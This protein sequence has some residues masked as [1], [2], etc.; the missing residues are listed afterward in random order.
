MS[1]KAIIENLS[2]GGWLSIVVILLSV[3]EITPIKISPLQWIGKRTN[4]EALDR[5]DK[6]EKKLDEHIAQSYRDKIMNFATMITTSGISNH[7]KE[8]WNEVINA[9]NNYEQYIADNNIPNG[10]CEEA[11]KFIKQSYQ[12][13]LTNNDFA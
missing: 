13:C 5:V 11:I 4:K 10:L 9:C 2:I 8:L 6:I 7:P 3:I 1:L 12:T